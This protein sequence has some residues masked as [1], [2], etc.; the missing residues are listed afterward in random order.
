M[1]VVEFYENL[2]S[3]YKEY[4]F[5]DNRNKNRLYFLIESVGMESFREALVE[6]SG[7][8]YQKSGERL[9]RMEQFDNNQGKVAL[10]DGSFALHAVVAGGIFSGSD[11]IEAAEIAQDR[12]GEIRLS[13]EQNLYITGVRDVEDVLS[14]DFFKKY[15]NIDSP[16]KNNLVACAGKNECSFGVIANKPDA[17]ETA[18]YLEKAVPLKD[19]KI[20]MYWSACVKGCGIHEWGD[21][22]FVGA[23][24]KYEGETVEAV[25]ILMGGS[26]SR[27]KEAVTILKAV[28]LFMAKELLSHL[29]KE[30]S[31]NRLDR[32]SFED[33]YFRY[34][35]AFSKGAIGFLMSFNYVLE[36]GGLNYRF[37]L[38]RFKPVG[39]MESFEIFAFGNEIY[40]R[41]T[42]ERAYLEIYDFMPVG[43]KKPLHPNK[44]DKTIPK[45]IAD[46]VYKMIH[47]DSL[48]RYRVFSEI[49]KDMGF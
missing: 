3:L 7:K 40:E 37:T 5:R 29:M 18:E 32:E 20:R 49:L 23:K 34:L 12:G 27:K 14:S 2:I 19:A 36:K 25:D 8:S 46:I 24:T 44:I 21:I 33:F 9:C 38:N 43:N 39:G 4:G 1:D 11:M 16:Y 10:K 35:S 15:K 41:L 30:Y 26:L 6:F 42:G 17:I 47:P 13:V 45:N 48:Q 28:P 31:E 22:G